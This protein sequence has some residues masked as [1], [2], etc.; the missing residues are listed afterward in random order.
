MTWIDYTI[1]VGC[2][3]IYIV[4][5]ALYVQRTLDREIT[6]QR[7]SLA[8]EA[9]GEPGKDALTAPKGPPGKDGT[10][11]FT[12][13]PEILKM[14]NEVKKFWLEQDNFANGMKGLF[15]AC[16][17]VFIFTFV[18]VKVIINIPWWVYVLFF[19]AGLAYIAYTFGAFEKLLEIQRSR[20]EKNFPTFE[21]TVVFCNP[22]DSL[23]QKWYD[24]IKNGFDYYQILGVA[25]TASKSDIQKAYDKANLKYNPNNQDTSTFVP[26]AEKFLNTRF[27]LA[28]EARDVL[29]HDATRKRYDC[30]RKAFLPVPKRAN[31]QDGN[32]ALITTGGEL[33][34]PGTSP[35]EDALGCI[36]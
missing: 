16:I 27:A 13:G 21:Q 4:S 2:V 6:A 36:W 7:P 25:P 17:A 20:A 3:I 24:D 19:V 18:Y 11:Q 8:K 35:I 29:S 14:Q 1:I 23:E 9:V 28:K 15:W 26:C 10:I 12:E 32:P 30:I 33:V 5:Y 34:I 31:V 22:Q